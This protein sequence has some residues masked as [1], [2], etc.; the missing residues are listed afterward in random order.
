MLILTLY[1]DDEGFYT[2]ALNIS[3][4]SFIT[5]L[6]TAVIVY[7]FKIKQI[8]AISVV[9][10]GLLFSDLMLKKILSKY[11]VITNVI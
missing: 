10:S 11:E 6:S 8:S 4:S 1:R 9:G 3:V 2:N 5:Y 7:C